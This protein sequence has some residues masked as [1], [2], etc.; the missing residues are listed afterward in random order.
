MDHHQSI[1]WIGAA[2][3]A[4]VVLFILIFPWVANKRS[5]ELD[6]RLREQRIQ[7]WQDRVSELKRQNTALE[8]IA[9]ALERRAV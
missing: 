8:R 7:Y 5:R 6:I 1:S 4:A 2:F 9:S 3:T